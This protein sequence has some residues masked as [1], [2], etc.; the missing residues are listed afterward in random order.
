MRLLLIEP[1]QGESSVLKRS[2]SAASF[3]IDV[4]TTGQEGSYLARTNDYDLIICEFL[5]P[6][7]T[8]IDVCKEL[9]SKRKHTP[10]I[11]LSS[12]GETITKVECLN[13]GADDYV[14]KP[15]YFEEILAR[16]RAILRRPQTITH[17]TMKIAD[18]ELNSVRHTIKR[19]GQSVYLTRKEFELLEYLMKNQGI[20]LSRGHIMEHV[21]DIHADIFS[22]TIETHILNLRRKIDFVPNQKFIHTIPGRGYKLEFMETEQPAKQK[23]PLRRL[24]KQRIRYRY[25]TTSSFPLVAKILL[26]HGK[27]DQNAF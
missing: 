15:F 9:R 6:D 16:V 17:A 23:T 12:L 11:I 10:F 4:A 3:T 24:A 2:L 20:V 5:L 7:R 8:G 13:G 22:N 18:L 1:D 26:L 14:T 25:N 21:W 19:A 27:S